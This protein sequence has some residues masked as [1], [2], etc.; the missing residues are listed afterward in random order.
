MKTIYECSRSKAVNRLT[1][2]GL[3]IIIAAIVF[4]MWSISQG[5][6]LISGILI[7]ILLILTM[8]SAFFIY[9]QYIIATDD[10]IGIHTLLHTKQINYENIDRIVRTDEQSMNWKTIRLFGIGGVFGY[11]GLFRSSTIGVFIAYVT[12][13]Q[14]TFIIYRKHGKP[15]AISVAEPDQFMPY[16]LKGSNTT[17]KDI[18]DTKTDT[19]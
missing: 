19:L 4:E 9:P 7:T 3:L 13:P 11:I 8:L 12:D 14:K 18:E 2:A 16:Y 17:N 5:F 15:I 6:N 1:A 10:G